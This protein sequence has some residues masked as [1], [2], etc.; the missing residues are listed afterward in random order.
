MLVFGSRARGDA[1][2]DRDLDLAVLAQPGGAIDPEALGLAQDLRVR[3]MVALA[4]LAS[5]PLSDGRHARL[6]RFETSTTGLR[7][8]DWAWTTGSCVWIWNG[9]RLAIE[10]IGGDCKRLVYNGHMLIE[11]F[12]LE[13]LQ[14]LWENEVE[15]NLTESGVHPYTLRELLSAE[16]I[17]DLLDLRLTYGWTNGSPGLRD[18]IR[19]E[20][21]GASRDQV[22]VTN[23]SAEANFLAMWTLLEAGDEIALMLPNYMQIWGLARSLGVQVRPFHLRSDGRRWRPDLEELER[24]VGPATKAIVVCNPNNPTGAVL[25]DGE[26]ERIVEI[27]AAADAWVYA[28]EVYKGVELDG[29]ERPSFFGRHDKV[30]V[31]SGLSKA[32]AHP[33]LRIGWL[34]GPELLVQSA[35]HRNDYTTITT[36]VLSEKVAEKVLEPRTRRRILERNRALLR[37]NLTLLEDWIAERPSCF[38]M[39]PP[40][41]GGMAFVE[42]TYEIGSTEL[43]TRLREERGVFVL[44]GDVYGID[45]HLRLGI[46]EQQQILA[47]GLEILGDFCDRL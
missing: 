6:R 21:P 1:R 40:E 9:S 46:G 28:D 25:T 15:I 5:L 44:P 11:E 2:P 24:I 17:A 32:L 33:G 45:H 43:S 27:A 10:S 8:I 39:V 4:H 31:A 47:R 3:L 37:Q 12:Q 23:G 29:E 30:A 19:Y 36:G 35:W 18:A 14:S 38:H 7:L 22:L 41:A 26:M 13:R 16:E 20:Y 34:V 42:Y